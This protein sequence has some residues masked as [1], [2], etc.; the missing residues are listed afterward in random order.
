MTENAAR[1]MIQTKLTAIVP[2]VQV[3][4][5]HAA[6]TRN[7]VGR[8]AGL[9]R[10]GNFPLPTGDRPAADRDPLARGR[11]PRADQ[12]P[13][14]NLQ[15]GGR[16]YRIAAKSIFEDPSKDIVRAAATGS[17]SPRTRAIS[18]RSATA[19]RR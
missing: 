15:R 7:S 6:G 17:S 16:V 12:N 13:Q 3:Q 10:N 14:I 18:S 1:K 8:S 11:H 4:L 5:A 9:P 2:D 19:A